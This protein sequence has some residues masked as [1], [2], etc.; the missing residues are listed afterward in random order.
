MKAALAVLLCHLLVFAPAFA[1]PAA[2]TSIK[3]FKAEYATLQNGS[4]LGRTTLELSDNHDGSWTLRS[5]TR[6][7][8]GLAKIA[9]IHIVETSRFRWQDGRPL[10]LAYDYKQ[11]GAFKQRT[12]QAKFDWKAN[13]VRVREG[14]EFRYATVPGLIDRQSVTLALAADLMHGAQRFDYKV[15]VKDHVEDMRYTRGANETLKVPAGSYATTVM[16]REGNDDDDRRRVGRVWFAE[17]L[18]WL[19][20]QIEQADRKGDTITLQLVSLKR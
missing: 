4:E 6:G 18:G 12:R 14:G 1:A 8:E 20:A 5:E 9:G 2:P 19:P 16:L 10:A 11:D 13:E 17:S 15:A 7:T 3:S